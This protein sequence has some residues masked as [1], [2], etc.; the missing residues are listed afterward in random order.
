LWTIFLL[1]LNC[2]PPDLYL[3]NSWNYRHEAL[4]PSFCCFLMDLS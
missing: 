2:D 4:V 1:A 3:L